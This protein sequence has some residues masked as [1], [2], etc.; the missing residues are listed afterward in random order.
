MYGAAAPFGPWSPSKGASVLI[1][2]PFVSIPVFL[3]PVMHH[4]G[5][6][7][8]ILFLVFLLILCC[9]ISH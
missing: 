2:P 8:P 3:R 4:S 1:Y 6:R 5:R 9:G 7:P